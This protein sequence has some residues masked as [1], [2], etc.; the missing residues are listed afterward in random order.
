MHLAID[1]DIASLTLRD[2]NN[3]SQVGYKVIVRKDS[4]EQTTDFSTKYVNANAKGITPFIVNK[5]GVYYC[6]LNYDANIGADDL[7][8]LRIILLTGE[9]NILADLNS[10]GSEN[11]IDLVRMK[12][13]LSSS[14]QTVVS[15]SEKYNYSFKLSGIADSAEGSEVI[16]QPYY[17]VD[18]VQVNGTSIQLK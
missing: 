18:G 8:K 10:D 6:D 16:L 2:V 3:V 11:I 7:A 9:E 1:G 17:I 5:S 4:E 14:S 12:K 13:V 15:D